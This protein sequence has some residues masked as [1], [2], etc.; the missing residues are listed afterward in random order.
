MRQ[1]REKLERGKT[2]C[3]RGR[4]GGSV[5]SA[6]ARRRFGSRGEQ[7]E[8]PTTNETNGTNGGREERNY[9]KRQKRENRSE[10]SG[11]ASSVLPGLG[12]GDGVIKRPFT[13]AHLEGDLWKKWVKKPEKWPKFE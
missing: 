5:W 12:R 2:G 4:G 3:R 10:I 11:G 8:Q 7:P 13:G 9:E 6:A 1:T